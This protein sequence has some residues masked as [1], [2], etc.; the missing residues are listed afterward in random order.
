M[1]YDTVNDRLFDQSSPTK[2][3]HH[4]STAKHKQFLAP[5]Y[6]TPVTDER[7]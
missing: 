5:L 4:V 3:D 7:E 1:H 6:F 2:S